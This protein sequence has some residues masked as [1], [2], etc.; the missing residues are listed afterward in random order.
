MHIVILEL[1]N[2]YVEQT[3]S[4]EADSEKKGHTSQYMES[5]FSKMYQY[6][7]VKAIFSVFSAI[8]TNTQHLY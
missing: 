7:E 3:P 2:L 4:T 8:N 6:I 1:S 5:S